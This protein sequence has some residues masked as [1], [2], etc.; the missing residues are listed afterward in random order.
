MHHAAL[1]H[2]QDALLHVLK[3]GLDVGGL[4]LEQRGVLLDL[5]DHLVERNDGMADLVH[6]AHRH[7]AREILAGGDLAHLG[8]HAR[9][10]PGD[11]AIQQHADGGEQDDRHAAH[12]ADGGGRAGELAVQAGNG[13]ILFAVLLDA[14]RLDNLFQ[15]V[16]V[17]GHVGKQEGLCQLVL[18]RELHVGGLLDSVDVAVDGLLGL[19]N[20]TFLRVAVGA[21]GLY[22]QCRAQG[23]FFRL[24]VVLG[25]R[26][27][28]G[29]RCIHQHHRR[30]LHVLDERYQVGRRQRAR[31][32][33][34]GHLADLCS[35]AAGLVDRVSADG[36]QRDKHQ[37]HQQCNAMTNGHLKFSRFNHPPRKK[38]VV[39][40][41]FLNIE[42]A[43]IG[44]R[45]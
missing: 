29:V 17:A 15:H 30:Q 13:F 1:D 31:H 32:H 23:G 4:L 9:E 41:A 37:H 14:Q 11:L 7:A 12:H 16:A 5:L 18:A 36:R 39:Q 40:Y 28:V 22:I 34:L 8:L 19:G 43:I 38:G 25:L 26:D 44:V 24:Q 35:A 45:R 6:A 20:Q 33:T 2:G 27:D 3:H 21:L 10:R 42:G